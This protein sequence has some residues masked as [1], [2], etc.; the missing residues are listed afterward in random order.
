MLLPKFPKSKLGVFG[1]VET[2]LEQVF[3][4]QLLEVCDDLLVHGLEDRGGVRWEVQHL[5]KGELLQDIIFEAGWVGR[6]IIENEEAFQGE[7][8]FLEI[9]LNSWAKSQIDPQ[10]IVG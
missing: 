7:I 8:V 9:P 4:V 5:D 6:G 2:P 3:R 10:K 1:D